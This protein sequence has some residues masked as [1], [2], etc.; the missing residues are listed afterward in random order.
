MPKRKQ[1]TVKELAMLSDVSVRT[2]HHYHDIGL[3][4]P[5][6]VGENGYRY[7]GREELLRLQQILFHR[8]LG[9]PLQRIAELLRQPDFDRAAALKAHRGWLEA[10]RKRLRRLVA[11]V[12]RTIAEIERKQEMN[13]EQ[14]YDGFSPEKQKHYEQWITERYGAASQRTIADSNA[15]LGAMSKPERTAF[16]EEISAIEADLGCA[17]GKGLD[18]D[19]TEVNAIIARHFAW[20]ARGWSR[21]PTR[22]AYAG[23]AELYLSHPDFLTRYESIRPGL[24]EFL[25]AAMRHY[26]SRME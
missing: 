17:F 3:L 7:Y 14:I 2:L 24:T 18:P 11:T 13:D 25:A 1:Y 10:E 15:A 22:E 26:A 23:L 9:L 12:D 8:E 19:S 16:L 20:V 6:F 5:A 21:A 4:I